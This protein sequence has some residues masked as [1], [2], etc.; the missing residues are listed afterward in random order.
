MENSNQ[1]PMTF[2]EKKSETKRIKT[3]FLSFAISATWLT[4]SEATEPL[5]IH[6]FKWIKLI[7]LK[8]KCEKKRVGVTL[9]FA[10]WVLGFFFVTA[11]AIGWLNDVIYP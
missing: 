3:V 10:T 1:H 7:Q 8:P 11:D 5:T 6:W 9:V 2:P 4:V